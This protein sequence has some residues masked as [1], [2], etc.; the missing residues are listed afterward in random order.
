MNRSTFFITGSDT[1]VGKTVLTCLLARHLRR[2]GV[3]V[4]AFEPVSGSRDITESFRLR[5]GDASRARLQLGGVPS[6]LCY[7]VLITFT[8]DD[9]VRR[10]THEWV[11]P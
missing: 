8:D 5:A 4:A 9:D 7:P 10:S 2:C 6:D 1:G 3:Q 11:C